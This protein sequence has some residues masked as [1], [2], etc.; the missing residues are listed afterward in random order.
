MLVTISFVIPAH[1]EQR[2]LP[3]T[4]R[5]ISHNIQQLKLTAEIIVV[6]DASTDN[7]GTVATELGARVIAVSLRN[8]GA[9]RNAGAAAATYPWLI[10]VDADTI[11]PA[12][13]VQQSL[14]SLA[15]GFA[16]GGAHVDIP[17]RFELF[18]VKR[19]MYYA[20]V[21]VW[22]YLFG[23][24]A[25][26]YMFCRKEHFETFGGFDEKYY[27][28]EEVFFSKQLKNIGNFRLVRPAVLTSA[29]KLKSYSVWELSRFLLVPLMQPFSMFQN[30]KGLEILYEDKR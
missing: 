20:V 3:A 6:N 24:A 11:V 22:Q 19:W 30:T 26:C 18:F 9:V 25:G 2:Y 15:D 14:E 21:I 29:R 8:I 12:Q 5:A 16:G 1:N 13:T 27:A 23:W 4:I 10:F 7:T 28:A 17:N